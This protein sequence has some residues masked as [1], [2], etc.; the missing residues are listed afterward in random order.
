MKTVGISPKTSG[1]TTTA[2]P[3]RP[4]NLTCNHLLAEK[5]LFSASMGKRALNLDL[6]IQVQIN[7][8]VTGSFT[9]TMLM[10]LSNNRFEAMKF[11]MLTSIHEYV[12]SSVL[13]QYNPFSAAYRHMYK[14]EVE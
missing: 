6:S 3:L 12:E 10:L 5:N 4:S 2:T 8:D 13:H 7:I 14:V 9:F 11:L 1:P